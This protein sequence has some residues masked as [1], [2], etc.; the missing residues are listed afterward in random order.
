MIEA[1]GPLLMFLLAPIVFAVLLGVPL[2]VLLWFAQRRDRF[3]DK[4][5]GFEVKPTSGVS[6]E[7]RERETHNG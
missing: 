1:I 6:P 4:R 7:Q 2:L 5:P 3:R